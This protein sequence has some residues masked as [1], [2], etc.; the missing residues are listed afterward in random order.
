MSNIFY[1]KEIK[2]FNEMLEQSKNKPVLLDFGAGWCGPC[3]MMDPIFE[4]ISGSQDAVIIA[5]VDV[6]EIPELANIY[7]VRSIPTI[8]GF[9]DKEEF[10]NRII[11]AVPQKFIEERIKEIM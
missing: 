8:I 1:I 3:R 6:D 4:R 9:K 10:G 2:D 7:N 11:G 5:K